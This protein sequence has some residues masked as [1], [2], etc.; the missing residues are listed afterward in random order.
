MWGSKV[1]RSCCWWLL[2]T[3][4]MTFLPAVMTFLLMETVSDISTCVASA[5]TNDVLFAVNTILPMVIDFKQKK[6]LRLNHP[7]VLLNEGDL[8]LFWNVFLCVVILDIGHEVWRVETDQHE[9]FII[10]VIT[11]LLCLTIPRLLYIVR[12][13]YIIYFIMVQ[14][15]Y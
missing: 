12:I 14:Y 3:V 6:Q 11:V 13:F 5:Y 9:G 15:I 2:P 4:N 7:L 8:F 10:R 1:K